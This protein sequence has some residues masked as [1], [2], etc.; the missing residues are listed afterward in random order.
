MASSPSKL[1]SI[2]TL[3]TTRFSD[4]TPTMKRNRGLVLH[5]TITI[6]HIQ[7]VK[8]KAVDFQTCTLCSHDKTQY[9]GELQKM[10]A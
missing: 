1:F 5:E 3:T 8:E 2:A 10:V 7:K 4:Y 9:H 6:Y